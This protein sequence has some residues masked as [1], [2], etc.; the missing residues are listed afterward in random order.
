MRKIN[1]LIVHCSASD[2]DTHDNPNVIREWHLQKGWHDCGY[3]YIITKDGSLSVMRP[4]S[5]KGAHC[6]GQNS[7]SI[8]IC[9]TG[10]EVFTEY[11]LRTLKK[12]CLNLCEIFEL[13]DTVI[14]PH[15]YFNN[16]K[17]C[18]VFGLGEVREYV[19]ERRY[20]R[21]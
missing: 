7:Y 8:G 20:K 14:Y 6:Y 13:H 18:P 4:I 11:Q 19:S 12:L 2:K 15:W 1:K 16:E 3:H 10:L 17:S 21:D 9:L 5:L